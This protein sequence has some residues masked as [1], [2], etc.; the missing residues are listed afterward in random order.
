M[1][2]KKD[3][4][5]FRGEMGEAIVAYELMKRG[6]DVMRHLGGQG[7]DLW[8]TK[9]SVAR[10]VEVKTTDPRLKTGTARKQLAVVLSKA[11]QDLAHF[12][13]Y[14]IHGF[15][16][17]FVIPKSVFQLKPF[18]AVFIGKDGK[19][20]SRGKYEQYRNKWEALD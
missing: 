7:Y 10:A 1:P 15:D 16:T 3:L 4:D 8:A 19:I 2:S 11:E 18:I 17:Y 6:W 12:L 5:K 20:G 9:G 13:V 14:Y